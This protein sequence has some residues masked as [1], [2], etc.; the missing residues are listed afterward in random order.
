M[1]EFLANTMPAFDWAFILMILVRFVLATFLSGLVG[2]E[3]EHSGRPAGLRTHVLV[4]VGACLVML[5]SEFVFH[6]YSGQTNLDPA[7]LGAQVISGV[8]FLGAGTIIRDG[9]TVKG[10]TTAASLWAVSCIGLACG[11]GFYSGAIVGTSV[12]FITLILFKKL[13]IKT[14]KKPLSEENSLLLEIQREDHDVLRIVRLIEE[15]Q[16]SVRSIQLLETDDPEYVRVRIQTNA[17]SPLRKAEI[18]NYLLQ[19]K[20]IVRLINP[21]I[22]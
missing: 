21:Q 2:Y 8:G 18:V 11:I 22:I 16:V 17:L 1:I 10:L 5:T 19:N 12:T 14:N 3:R 9:N 15:L 7:R 6:K 4:G 20:V 13:E